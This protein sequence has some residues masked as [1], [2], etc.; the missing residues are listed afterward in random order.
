MGLQTFQY[1]KSEADPRDLCACLA[2]KIDEAVYGT[3][4]DCSEEEGRST[5]MVTDAR[6]PDDGRLFPTLKAA[7]SAGLRE[8]LEDQHGGRSL[9]TSRLSRRQRQ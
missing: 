2:V 7:S 3:D 1:L 9:R 8:A 6:R 4:G 5:L